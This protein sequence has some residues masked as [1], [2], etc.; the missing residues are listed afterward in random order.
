[1]ATKDWIEVTATPADEVWDRSAPIEGELIK[2]QHN[3]G[4]Y[5][6]EMYTI[7]TEDGEVAIWGSTTLDSKLAELYL[8]DQIRIEPLG[9][10]KSK[11]GNRE[12]W[13]FKV[14]YI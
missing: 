2:V 12:Y 10:V 11:A 3:I 4:P 13:D 9:K 14:S 7:L 5:S 6:S 8:H 1:M